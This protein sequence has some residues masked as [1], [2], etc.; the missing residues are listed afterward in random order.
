LNLLL[1]IVIESNSLGLLYPIEIPSLDPEV[2][3][4]DKHKDANDWA[5]DTP[6][7]TIP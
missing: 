4:N 7:N 6:H 2:D 1:W 5:N 3:A